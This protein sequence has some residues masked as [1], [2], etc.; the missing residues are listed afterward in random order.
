MRAS[1]TTENGVFRRPSPSSLVLALG[2]TG[3]SLISGC[4]VS[5]DAGGAASASSD[6][7]ELAFITNG[8]ADFWTIAEAGAIAGG[9]E[10]D[11][12][13]DVLMPSGGIS[14]QKNMVDDCLTKMVDGIA[15][16]PINPVDQVD[17][18]NR[19]AASTRLLTHDSDAP[20]TDRLCYI[21]MDNYKAGWMCGEL[22]R[23][24]LP[25]GGK[26]AVFIGR[27]EQDNARRR[28]QGVIDAVL[29]REPDA[30]RYDAPDATLVS[31]DGF[32]I[33]GTFTDQFDYPL[34]KANVEDA[35][36]VH[37]D[38][39]ACVGLF[40]YNPPL[41]LQALKVQGRLGE[42]AV[43]AFDEDQA[44]L[45]GI[46]DGTVVGTVVQNPFLYGKESIRVLAGLHRGATLEELGVGPNGVLD[47][48]AR[49]I[50]P[51]NVA[52]F[53]AELDRSLGQGDGR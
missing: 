38:L 2:L 42:V 16:S 29:G 3:L 13:V 47:I 31:E 35:L 19:A 5:T 52:E 27:L 18:I 10:F 32:E 45:D 22:V 40:G 53:S 6:A 11:A 39:A 7:P 26:I 34:A 51:D 20:G 21:G 44:T 49:V 14:D 12:K 24:A 17:L 25:D 37:E 50:G 8:V 30:T 28:R 4:G 43:I 33:V 48:P 36:T 9:V 1:N 46:A 15:I 23:S 41:I